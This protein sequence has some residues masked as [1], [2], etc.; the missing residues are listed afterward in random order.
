MKRGFG[1]VLLSFAIL[2]IIL[3]S[4]FVFAES[5]NDVFNES[6]LNEEIFNASN[7]KIEFKG[8]LFEITT[9]DGEKHHITFLPD[10][11]SDVAKSR[12][13]S[14]TVLNISLEEIIH[15]N[16]P[17]VVYRIQTE[18]EGR[19]LGIFKLILKA[20]TIIDSVTE[21]ILDVN[22]PWWTFLITGLE[23]PD[24]LPK[25]NT[26]R[27]NGN[28]NGNGG[29]IDRIFGN[30]KGDSSNGTGDV[31]TNDTDTSSGGGSSGG[32]GGG[33]GGGSSGNGGDD[34]GSTICTDTDEGLNY[35]V[36]GYVNT[37]INDTLW[38]DSC[39]DSNILSEKY[40]VSGV[41]YE[42]NETCE[43][44][45]SDGA[46]SPAPYCTDTD[47]GLDYTIAGYVDS[48]ANASF[49]WD[50]CQD[51]N[52]LLETYCISEIPHVTAETCQN[53]CFNSICKPFP[54]ITLTNTASFVVQPD[55]YENIIVWKHA[56]ASGTY[57]NVIFHSDIYSCDFTGAPSDAN[58]EWCSTLVENG[59]GLKYILND[60]N[61]P[62]W[63][64][65]YGDIVVWHDDRNGND[66]IYIYNL[67]EDQET[68]ITSD[69]SNQNYA[70]IHG[71]IIVWLDYRN[72]DS[73]VYM[74]DLGT[75]QE[76]QI[77]SGFQ[78][79]GWVSVYGD[80][81]VYQDDRNGN[82][83]IYMYDLGTSQETQI[84]TNN[85]DQTS[86][87]IYED[88]IVWRDKRHSIN[89]DIYMYNL[90]TS[91][92]TRLTTDTSLARSA[93][94]IYGDNIAYRASGNIYIYNLTASQE[95][96][97]A[98]YGANEQ[99]GNIYG[100]KIILRADYTGNQIALVTL[101]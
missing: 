23:I 97:V 3:N 57:P 52:I 39:Q 58:S 98:D 26:V 78:N 38:W 7:L 62:E 30:G 92:E 44:G 81:I 17:R 48:L 27:E 55:I 51:S 37:S 56:Y 63:A 91:Q 72:G 43:Y 36:K 76:T 53:G 73:D 21:E 68:Q 49:W 70:Q 32:G 8:F 18:H 65:I 93:P 69:N 13:N 4:P 61:E 6:N 42:R 12:L 66:D 41:S 14:T 19:F 45:C 47:G 1:L 87:D 83:D 96:I 29:I 35:S 2:G 67:T 59:G 99:V 16:I 64:R 60:S 50:S 46:C 31:G 90:S 9:S 88:V 100:N 34:A 22:V 10:Q 15:N 71:D 80:K 54:L 101:S 28:G 89:G 74:Y 84:T 33:G 82:S 85:A 20:E 24:D 94:Y 40:C 5:H 79:N 77:S 11:A 25:D 95:I 86:P 75:S